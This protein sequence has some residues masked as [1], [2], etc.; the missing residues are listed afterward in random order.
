MQIRSVPGLVSVL[1][2]DLIALCTCDAPISGSPHVTFASPLEQRGRG[3]DAE[4]PRQA[5]DRRLVLLQRVLYDRPSSRHALLTRHLLDAAL[6]QARLEQLL[7][8]LIS[9]VQGEEEAS[10]LHGHH[11]DKALAL[12]ALAMLCRGNPPVQELVKA[13]GSVKA[14]YRC[15]IGNLSNANLD[16]IVFAL[17]MLS[18]LLLHVS[19]R[20]RALACV[21]VRWRALAC[22]G[23]V[24]VRTLAPLAFGPR[25]AQSIPPGLR[26]CRL[27]R[28]AADLSTWRCGGGGPGG[29]VCLPMLGHSWPEAVQ[30]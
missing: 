4:H 20:W 30:R 5:I 10:P 12:G 1:I 19:V 22:I 14:L 11:A 21:G 23:V 3:E 15:L 18:S 27:R 28:C 13:Q 26:H 24:R 16:A 25:R 7:S 29:A 6:A 8:I 9:V 17:S 2:G